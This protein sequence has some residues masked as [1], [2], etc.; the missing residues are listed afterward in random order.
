MIIGRHIDPIPLSDTPGWIEHVLI[1]IPSY[2]HPVKAFSI[3][4]EITL[5]LISLA[6]AALREEVIAVD[7]VLEEYLAFD[8][9]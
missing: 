6:E 3:V 9:R 8:N 2:L 4:H 1:I 7:G 5:L